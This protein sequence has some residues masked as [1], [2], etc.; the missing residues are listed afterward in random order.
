MHGSYF[1][2]EGGSIGEILVDLTGGVASKVVLGPNEGSQGE[3]GAIC[4]V[5]DLL[6]S[7]AK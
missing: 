5:L 4:S 1:A 7:K 3:S 2:L 6:E